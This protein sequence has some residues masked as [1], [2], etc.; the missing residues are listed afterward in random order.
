[1]NIEGVKLISIPV[2][3]DNRGKLI[4]TYVLENFIKQSQFKV[5]ESWFTISKKNTIR[6]MHMQV[7]KYP[8]RKIV[9]LIQGEIIDVLLDTRKDSPTY[10]KFMEIELTSET[11]KCIL[12]DI[13]VGVAHGY[14]VLKENSVVQYFADEIHHNDSDV[15]FHFQS[16]GYDW[17]IDEPIL[18]L[19][20]Q[21]LPHFN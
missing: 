5:K 12:I 9:A 18:S 7:G 16:F 21:N 8:S 6:G 19:K 2:F 10:G 4:K 20:D 1:M 15:G 14:K 13:P 11:D 17:K 3:E